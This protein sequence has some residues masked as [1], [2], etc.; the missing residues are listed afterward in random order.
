MSSHVFIIPEPHIWDK[1]FKN[2][3]KYPRE[4]TAYLTEI[5]EKILNVEGEKI[6]I[7]PG[8]IFHR[9]FADI[10]GLVSAFNLFKE[11]NEITNGNVYSCVGNHELSYTDKNPFWILADDISNRYLNYH[12]LRAFGAMQPG[13]KVVDELSIGP[14]LFVFGHFNRTD[15]ELNTSDKDIVLITH[16][17][18]NE[19][20]IDAY[21]KTKYG[22]TTVTDYMHTSGLKQGDFIPA[23]DRIKYVFVGHMHTFIGKFSVNEVIKGL[24]MEFTLQYLG[25]LGRTSITEINDNAL[26][27]IVPH[28]VIENDSYTYQPFEITLKPRADVVIEQIVTENAKKYGNVKIM[29][30][31]VQNSTFGETPEQ[32]IDRRLANSPFLLELFHAVYSN[33][34]NSKLT[35]I[36]GGESIL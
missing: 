32:R 9:G 16:N 35:E 7:F 4:I 36:I 27:R 2:R 3:K 21:M 8:D 31:L 18:I 13:I 6:I 22:D 23:S 11:L 24:N 30:S 33:E 19:P 5:K 25:S 34:L 12:G 1:S 17:A 10:D 28:F 29:R 15:Y 14:L 26:V 20:E